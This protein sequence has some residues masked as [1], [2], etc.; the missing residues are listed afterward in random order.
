MS[1]ISFG[2]RE[3]SILYD[4]PVTP[5][6]EQFLIEVPVAEENLQRIADQTG[7]LYFQAASL[8][9][10]EAV[11]ADI[12]SAVGSGIEFT[13]IADWFAAVAAALTIL[14]GGLSL[15]WFQRLI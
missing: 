5:Q 4:D 14:A 10:L 15:W 8:E 11:Y 7:G 1:T 3:G 9:E 6:V 13:E 2:T 12:G